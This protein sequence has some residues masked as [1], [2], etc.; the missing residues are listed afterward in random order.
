LANAN[1]FKSFSASYPSGHPFFLPASFTTTSATETAFLLGNG[2]QAIIYMPTGT[3]IL[4]SQTQVS[5]NA[6][7]AIPRE[8]GRAAAW[9]SENRPFFNSTSFNDR[10]FK[11]RATG[12]I[13]G[14][15]TTLTSIAGTVSLYA[16]QTNITTVTSGTKTA[17]VASGAILGAVKA[18]WY[19]E[20]T[21][22]WDSTSLVLQPVG[23][24]MAQIGSAYTA[25]TAASITS[26]ALTQ[27]SFGVTWTF[28]TTSTSNAV[29]MTELSLE[30]V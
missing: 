18:N 30:V 20:Q 25:T 27:L 21:F 5:P 22:I 17:T 1:T 14:G 8:S 11:V 15:G 19:V 16:N 10:A 7:S 4:G 29:Q 2:T 3:E 28:A 13:S 23:N 24:Y 12:F 26:V 9:F 6:N